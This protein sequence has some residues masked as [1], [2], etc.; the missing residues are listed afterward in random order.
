VKTKL[1][2]SLDFGKLIDKILMICEVK[3][4]SVNLS[5]D[6]LMDS[7]EDAN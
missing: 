4:S 1:N 7:R 2:E 5:L 6:L 3:L